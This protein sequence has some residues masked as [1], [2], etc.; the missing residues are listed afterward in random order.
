MVKISFLGSCREVGRSA[1]LIESK[2]GTKCMFDYG[3]RFRGEERLPFEVDLDDLS[4]VALTHC[5]IDHSGAIPYL[6]RNLE[7]PLYTNPLTL[8]VIE[9]LIKDMI[10]ISKFPYPFGYRELN[11]MMANTQ[12]LK[13]NIRQKIAD[14][15]YITFINAGHVPGSV[16][17]LIETDNKR[18]LYTGDINNTPTNLVDPTDINEIPEIDALIT[19]S[20]Y[21]LRDHPPREDLEEVF[22]D[23]IKNITEDGGRVI[24][25]AFGVA[26]SQEALLILKKHN[27][28]GKV[29][30]DGLAKKISMDYLDYPDSLKN[31]KD[32]RNAI[33]NSKFISK[34]ERSIV[35]K[36]N[37]VLIAPSGM[38]KGGAA[39]SF[40]KSFLEDP[41]SA[42][43]LIGYQVEGSP[44]RKLLDSG[45]FRYKEINR[46]NNVAYNIKIRAK[47]DIDYFDFSSHADSTHLYQ[48]IENLNFINESKDVFCVHGDPKA[49]TTMAGELV[50][51]DY[52][53]VAPEIGE[54]YKI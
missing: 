24:I 13:N 33:K 45:V 15:F 22:V 40:M 36:S 52:N 51:K 42:I 50:K 14:D 54:I 9:T 31:G 44:G 23:N 29:F 21:V 27:Y 3:I 10:I 35:K 41:K 19:E 2:G 6:Y 8:R 30:I 25:P 28:N 12:F 17:I 48:Y 43:Y 26:R 7:I 38:L 4:A 53:S 34:K 5:H 1:I 49:T 46:R 11:K 32:L 39:I 47:C 20:T 37:G 16:S 18:I